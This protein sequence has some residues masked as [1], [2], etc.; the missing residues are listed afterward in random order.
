MAVLLAILLVWWIYSRFFNERGD[1]YFPSPSYAFEQTLSNSQRV[2]AGFQVTIT[3][4]LAGFALS[5]AIGVITAL[6]LSE[7]RFVR[8]AVLPTLLL[9]YSVPRAILAPLFLVWFG[10]TTWSI[11]LYVSWFGFFPVFISSLTGFSQVP[12]E[13]KQLGGATGASRWQFIRKVKIWSALPYTVSGIKVAIP[14][15][16]EGAIIAEFIA[17]GQGTGYIITNS[18]SLLEEG[19]M[20]GVVILLIVFSAVMFKTFEILID[21]LVP[22]SVEELRN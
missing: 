11:A 15:A 16:I 17:T 20:I 2:I 12:E 13:L 22:V 4:F 7:V 21:F 9:F 10:M 1:I 18:L 19:L 8:Q 6:V 5:I 14:A 3:E